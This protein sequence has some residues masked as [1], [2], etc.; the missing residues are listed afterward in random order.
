[1]TELIFWL[2]MLSGGGLLSGRLVGELVSSSKLHL[3][4][5]FG[6]QRIFEKFS[7]ET[8]IGHLLRCS[9]CVGF[10]SRLPIIGGGAWQVTDSWMQGLGLAAVSALAAYEADR[11][12]AF[13]ETATGRLTEE[14]REL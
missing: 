11:Q 5:Y 13:K 4:D 14:G 7:P 12:W 8:L 3:L 10:W 9:L 6:R 2:T 1:M